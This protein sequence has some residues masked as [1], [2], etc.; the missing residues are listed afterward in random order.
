M[1]R[2]VNADAYATSRGQIQSDLPPVV[3][4]QK[5]G[6]VALVLGAALIL[7]AACSSG[8]P[9]AEQT[10]V[11]STALRIPQPF[12]VGQQVGLGNVTIQATRF[13]HTGNSL[14]V[15]VAATNETSHSLSID[16]TTAF[17]IFYG[18]GRH[19]PDSV[20]T[21]AT[22]LAPMH[23]E[24]IRLEFTVPAHYQY[25][26]LWFSSSTA[27]T[28]SATIVLRGTSSST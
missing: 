6:L 22:P 21:S 9:A 8:S 2:A 13:T 5:R 25:P 7:G 23:R 26:L 14:S 19:A 15:V 28:T 24:T 4:L 10:T 17:T 27:G 20:T 12:E 18:T 11:S 1:R 3:A 16:P